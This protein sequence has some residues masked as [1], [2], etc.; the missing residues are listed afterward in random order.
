MIIDLKDMPFEGRKFFGREPVSAIDL[1]DSNVQIDH[2][3]QYDLK[4][5]I[6]SDD[7]IVTGKISIKVAFRCV[8]CAESFPFDVRIGEFQCVCELVDNIESVD[9]TADIREAII[10]AFPNYPI[11]KS[12][13]KGL[14]SGC[15][16]NLN[17]ET[18]NCVSPDD[19]RWGALDDLDID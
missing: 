5:Y 18:C 3:A 14:C 6:A 13:C 15:G 1:Q 11:C 7:L 4:A 2:P 9:L 10:L 19:V 17:R 16:K 8:K 12:D